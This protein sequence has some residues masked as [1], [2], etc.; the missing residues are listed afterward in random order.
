L[1][2]EIFS[3][4]F[5][6][7]Y[8]G[9]KHKLRTFLQE[10]ICQIVGL[11]LSQKIFCDMFA[12][13][14]TVGRVFKN[15][16]KKVISNDLEYF[17]Y[18][19]NKNYIQ[20]TQKITQKESYISMLN[21][22]H[23]KDDGFIFKNYSQQSGRVYFSDANAKKIDTIRAKIEELKTAK[24]IDERSYFFL[25]A[26]LIE[27]C[28]KVAN[29]ASVYSAYLKDLKKSASED[30]ILQSADFEL[31]SN[32]HEVYNEDSNELIKRLKGDILYLDPPYNIRQYGANYHIL[33]TIALYDDF[34]PKGKTG[35][36]EYQRS[37]YCKT[38]K[39]YESFEALIKNADFEYIFLSY[40]DEGF[41][42]AK[43][44]KLIMQKY[45]QYELIQKEY[46]RYASHNNHQKNFTCESLHV[47]KK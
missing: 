19:L 31:S 3:Y 10:S 33:N 45:G 34:I 2:Q 14:G 5:A 35:L 22:L 47:I 21:S 36:R 42:S 26:S 39:V 8:I 40:N 29:T 46:R 41:M 18:V 32:E 4:N 44:I 9:S 23:V 1:Q 25:L 38:N 27:S 7:N 16:V 11:D 17:A 20:N 30:F 15:R 12:G 13:T 43:D 37:N 6:M 28:D 24:Q